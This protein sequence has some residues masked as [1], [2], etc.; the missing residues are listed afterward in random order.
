M[1]TESLL[2]GEAMHEIK[3][4][5]MDFLAERLQFLGGEE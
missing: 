3:W 2:V 4:D 1:S 5:K